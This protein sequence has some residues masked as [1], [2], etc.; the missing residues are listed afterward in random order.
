M[1]VGSRFSK[2]AVAANTNV[3][4]RSAQ[5]KTSTL[6]FVF[7]SSSTDATA[8]SF[9]GDSATLTAGAGF[10]VLIAKSQGASGVNDWEVVP[11]EELWVR[12]NQAGD[13]Y[14]RET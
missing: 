9:A 4:V 6:K 5:P 7:V 10:P 8:I 1:A 14:L 11:G 13:L 3:K 12:S 2:T